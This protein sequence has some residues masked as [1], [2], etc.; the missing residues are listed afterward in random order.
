MPHSPAGC[1]SGFFPQGKLGRPMFPRLLEGCSSGF[2]PP[3]EAEAASMLPRLPAGEG[4]LSSPVFFP[5][6]EALRCSSGF[7]PP[8]EAGAVLMMPRLP[9]GCSL[10]FRPPREAGA[11][12]MMP[13]SPSFCVPWGFVPQGKLGR[14]Q[15]CH[16]CQRVKLFFHS[17]GFHLPGEVLRCSLG[18]LPPREAGA[19]SMMPRLPASVGQR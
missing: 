2:L 5:P 8:S 10:G 19:A 3:R 16:A 4:L 12:S 17:P 1:S 9:E 13:S 14:R 7:C 11:A 6:G 18:F 15:C